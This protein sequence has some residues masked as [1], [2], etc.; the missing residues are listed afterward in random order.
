M[1]ENL[2]VFTVEGKL[3]FVL[4]FEN[5]GSIGGVLKLD[6]SETSAS[7]ILEALDFGGS[8]GTV[9]AEEVME[10][11]LS[12]FNGEVANEKVGLDIEFLTRT[13]LNRNTEIFTFKFK[14]VHL[15]ASSL[16]SFLRRE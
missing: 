7:S 2:K 13:S 9:L 16:S 1:F 6:V 10:F 5:L 14:V 8:N 12:D 11:L 15:I 4:L 3:G